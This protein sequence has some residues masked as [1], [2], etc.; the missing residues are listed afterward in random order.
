MT[1]QKEILRHLQQ[2]NSLT[3]MDALNKFNCWALA[4]RIKDL[5]EQGHFIN[6]QM[7]TSGKK[8]YASYSLKKQLNLF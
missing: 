2:G 1:Q 4:A 8:T 5:R 6:T 3:P 7:I